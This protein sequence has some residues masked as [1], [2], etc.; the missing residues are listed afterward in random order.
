ML[1]FFKTRVWQVRGTC[2]YACVC[3]QVYMPVCV[4]V[5]VYI[6]FAGARER[7]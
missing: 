4:P 1:F 5:R 2:V 3:V 7:L 6:V